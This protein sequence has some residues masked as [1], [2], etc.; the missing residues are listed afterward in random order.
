MSDAQDAEALAEAVQKLR[1][2]YE[3]YFA[4]VERFEPLKE[5]TRIKKELRRLMGVRSNNTA[6]KFK[7]QS[8]QATLVTYENHW[9]RIV[10]QIEEGTF[11]RDKL[12][13]QRHLQA[14]K[15][16]T[17]DV[18]LIEDE[19]PVNDVSSEF[20]SLDASE[21]LRSLEADDGDAVRELVEK[22]LIKKKA[23]TAE[24][25]GAI[26]DS[27]LPRADHRLPNADSRAPI[28][29]HRLPTA[30]SRAPSADHRLPTAD[31]RA[32]SADHRLPMADRRAPTAAS[33]ERAQPSPLPRPAVPA[34]AA[35]AAPSVGGRTPS[36]ADGIHQLHS[37]FSAARAQTGETKAIS[38]EALAETIRK[39]TAAVKAQLGCE[40]VEFKVAIK[41]GKAVLKAIPK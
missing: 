37:A 18:E 28:A 9:D 27:R 36:G 3:Q 35:K 38:V 16:V 11:K 26:A 41:D 17:E 21:A 29:D 19:E 8:T 34:A 31:S 13:A 2:L 33:P 39:Q 10:R 23:L 6:Y 32:P 30:D 14:M 7:M 40:R 15:D 5:R 20:E 12:K 1:I 22:G 24:G 4:G 25:R